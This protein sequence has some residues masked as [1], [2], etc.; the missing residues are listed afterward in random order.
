MNKQRRNPIYWI[1]ERPAGDFTIIPNALARD[2][3][4][5]A[6][7]R[8]V[9]LYL[10]S[11]RDGWELSAKSIAETLRMGRRQAMAA[12]RELSDSRW[13]AVR[14]TGRTA[15]E[16]FAHPSRPL[17]E[18]EHAELVSTG[19]ILSSVDHPIAQPPCA[20]SAQPHVPNQHNPHVP[21]RNNPMCRLGTTKKT[22]N[23]TNAE[24]QQEDQQNTHVSAYGLVSDA[25]EAEAD[26]PGDA[27]HDHDDE[28][29][30]NVDYIAEHP[31]LSSWLSESTEGDDEW[32]EANRAESE[33]RHNMAAL[34]Q[35]ICV[36]CR[37][38]LKA[39]T[40][41]AAARGWCEACHNNE[42]EKETA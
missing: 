29:G 36:R 27:A 5:S 16:Y 25:R 11:H 13:I 2:G 28:P 26:H 22:K 1:G 12:I 23:K 14:E 37:F 8:S 4:L 3:E 10:W 19:A 31:L 9:A 18:S 17:T 40:G 35:R 41:P 34:A 7:A 39:K 24:D 32:A 6:S 38:D 21:I 20:E 30:R 33:R 42:F 15:R